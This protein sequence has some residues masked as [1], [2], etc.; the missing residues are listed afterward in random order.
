MGI[1]F[2]GSGLAGGTCTCLVGT[3]IEGQAMTCVSGLKSSIDIPS[4]LNGSRLTEEKW[5]SWSY[6]RIWSFPVGPQATFFVK[7]GDFWELIESEWARE[8]LST[9]L[10]RNSSSSSAPDVISFFFK[11]VTTQSLEVQASL[12][13]TMWSCQKL[14]LIRRQVHYVTKQPLFGI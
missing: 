1:W 4:Q 3:G 11:T 8:T 9:A 14:W 7:D 6:G 2:M 13:K 12:Q 5:L 10:G